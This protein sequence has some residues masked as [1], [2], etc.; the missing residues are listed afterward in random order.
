M[1]RNKTVK[2]ETEKS[3]KKVIMKP[4]ITGN[5]YVNEDGVVFEKQELYAFK[6][7]INGLMWYKG[8]DGSDKKIDPNTI[9]DDISER[10]RKDLLSSDAYAKGYI[11]EW[12]DDLPSTSPNYNALNDNQIDAIV[13]KFK[14]NKDK[15]EFRKIIDRMDSIF[16][17]SYF[18]DKTKNALP[19]YLVQYCESRLS[20]LK[21]EDDERSAVIPKKYKKEE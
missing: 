8:D 1:T 15:D 20:E 11:V 10:E 7:R 6:S 19:G 9:R 4:I 21:E 17:L 3:S 18:I 2:K 13:K 5:Q 12:T 14:R 16:S